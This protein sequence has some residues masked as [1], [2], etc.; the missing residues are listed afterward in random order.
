MVGV[1]GVQCGHTQVPGFGKCNRMIHR[2]AISNFTDHD[3]I[4][5]LAQCVFESHC[6]ILGIGADFALCKDTV[7]VLMHEFDRV[8]NGDDVAA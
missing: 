8:F 6:P 4:G 5:R 1:I 2:F 7:A 3:D